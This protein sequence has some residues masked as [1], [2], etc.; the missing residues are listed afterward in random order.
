MLNN[1]L[2]FFGL[3][4]LISQNSTYLT[5]KGIVGFQYVAENAFEFELVEFILGRSKL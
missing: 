1:Q 2:L 4:L 5:D 3:I